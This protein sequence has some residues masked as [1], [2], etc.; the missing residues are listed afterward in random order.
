MPLVTHNPATGRPLAVYREH[1]AREIDRR[2]ARARKA[3]H[4]WRTVPPARRARFI[5]ALGRMLR[6]NAMAL[7]A[8]ATDEMGKPITQAR[9]EIEKCALL[10]EHYVKHGPKMLADEIPVAAPRQAHVAYEPL[11]T[12]LAIMPWNFPYWQV[13]RA[14]VP[15]LLAGNAMLLKHSPNV[16][17]C[18]LRIERLFTSAGFP[19]G[20]FQT[21]LI[22]IHPIA[23]LIADPRVHGVTL[24]G[25]NRAGRIVASQA[26]A[27]MKPGVFE[28]GGS[29]AFLVLQDA[30]VDRAAELG[31]FARLINSGQ[32]CLCAKRF[33]VVRSQ[34]RSFTKR[35]VERIAARRVGDPAD[36]AT[37]IGPLARPD[38]R[39]TLHAQVTRSIRLGARVLLG[40]HPLPGPGNFYASTVL[41]GVRP[42]MPA[43]DEEV[44]G[45]VAAIM[46]ARDEADAIRIANASCYGLG[47]TVFT[48]SRAAARRTIRALDAGCVFV[49]D[50][51][52]S[53]PELPFGG[54][55]ESGHGRELGIWG[56][57]AFT[58]VKTV[59]I[60]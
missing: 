6:R 43:A 27:A 23:G 37:D 52:R 9:G 51:V 32:S 2:L 38:L 20:L 49:N 18:A 8:Q 4:A 7:A 60:A 40:G 31:A 13:F 41:S 5:A 48:G 24:T 42:G 22:G 11:G 47:A 19:A 53:A 59:W 58:N 25:S 16:S 57:R 12:V 50:I 26:G 46:A 29:D 1:S 35:L 55:K 30:D 39:D 3:Q 14:A 34:L 54:V 28:L 15:A 21:L 33:I 17:G 10:C 45:P 44:F 36:P 56:A